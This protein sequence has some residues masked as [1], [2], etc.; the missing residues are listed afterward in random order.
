MFGYIVKMIVKELKL[1]YVI[2]IYKN[3]VVGISYEVLY[4]LN[5]ENIFN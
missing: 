1:F 3:C 2:E 4:K 5:E